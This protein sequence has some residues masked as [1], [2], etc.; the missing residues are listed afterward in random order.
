MSGRRAL[1]RPPGRTYAKAL[2]R[3]TPAPAVDLERAREQHAG[4]I[5]ALRQA[6]VEVFEL[7]PDDVRPDAVFVQDRACILGARAIFGRSAVSS[8]EGEE[9]PI[10]EVLRSH[11]PAAKLEAPAFLDWGDVLIAENRLFVGLSERTNE[12]AVSQLRSILAPRWSIAAAPLPGNLLH[13]LSG[14][15]YLGDGSLLA[16]ASLT[17][18]AKEH[19][20]TVVTVPSDEEAGAN[21]LTLE[22]E[23]IVP[24]GYP[25]TAGA[26]ARTG[27]R[28]CAVSMSEFE[29]RDGGVTCLS[30]LY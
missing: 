5:R 21:V 6:G 24:A 14:C 1:V 17:G 28:V 9:A 11:F 29:K 30:I 25:G 2:T 20:F 15:S 10:L 4:Y 13:L 12:E 23:V 16:I 18:F 27:R 3:Q 7:P 26:I 19:G 22:S 8:R